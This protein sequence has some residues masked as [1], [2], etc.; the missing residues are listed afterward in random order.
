[1]VDLVPLGPHVTIHILDSRRPWNLE[2]AFGGRG[3]SSSDDLKHVRQVNEAE[4]TATCR[5][6]AW[7]DG[8]DRKLQDLGKSWE[9]L[10][11]R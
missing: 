5:V 8:V 10:E 4:S 3:A 9:A 6:F 7:D 11:V 1:M 2:N